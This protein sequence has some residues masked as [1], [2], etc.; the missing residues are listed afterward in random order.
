MKIIDLSIPIENKAMEPKSSLVKRVGYKFGAIM[1]CLEG[2]T[3]KGKPLKTYWN[4]FLFFIGIKRIMPN[5]FPDSIG[6]SWENINTM[7][8]RGTHVDAPSHYG[9]ICNGR[10]AKTCSD[11]PLEWFFSDGVLLDMSHK[12]KG[13]LI[14]V[15]DIKNELISIDYKLK[16]YDIVLIKTGMDKLWDNPKYLSDYPGLT[17]SAVEWIIKQGVKVIGI[18]SYSLDLPSS[19]MV[20]SYLKDKNKN[21]LWPVHMLG[22]KYEYC[23]IE[24]LAN[25]DKL[26]KRKNFKICSFPINIKGAS[27]GWCRTVAIID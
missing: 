5:A 11:L 3:L 16:E 7:S 17:T 23:H 10:T 9:P 13:E 6:L 26:P 1:L 21:H 14:T 15:E 4:Y 27:A 22:R 12:K 8:H 20:N 2:L 18:D 19:I 25:L 24:K